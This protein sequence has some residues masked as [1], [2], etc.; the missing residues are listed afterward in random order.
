M[1]KK[2]YNRI[3]KQAQEDKTRE[4]LQYLNQIDCYEQKEQRVLKVI[5]SKLERT[6]ENETKNN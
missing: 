6:L 3:Y 2:T 5:R 1:R 4:I